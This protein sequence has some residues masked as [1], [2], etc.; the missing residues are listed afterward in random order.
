MVA[1]GWLEREVALEPRRPAV[2]GGLVVCAEAGMPNSGMPNFFGV[3]VELDPRTIRR[4]RFALILS[5]LTAFGLAY[6]LSAGFRS[7]VGRAV[8][9][10]SRGDVAGLRDYILSFGVWAPIVSALLMVLQAL[11]LPL[12]AF[13]V[14]FANGLAFGA[15]WGGILSLLSA[16]LAAALSFWI[17]RLL[18][19]RPVEALVGD[20]NLGSADR[21]FLRWGT[22]AVLIARLVPIVSFDVI[23]YA[24]GLT[25][26]RF[27]GF[28]LATVVGMAPAT[29]VYAYLGERAPH[30]V[31]ALLVAFGVVIAGAV[32][33]TVVRWRK[34]GKRLPLSEQEDTIEEVERK[35]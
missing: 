34:Q 20:R 31:Q 25:R 32:V 7:E 16:T 29:F 28:V 24:A 33:A 18:G 26:M 5:A 17:A 10:L 2:M 13:V 19:R 23:S 4:V 11:M 3:R 9:I 6:L 22:Y 1:G 12:P 14:T 30:F 35:L 27:W 15:F 8:A 21:W